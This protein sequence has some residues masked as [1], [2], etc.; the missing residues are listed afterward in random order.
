MTVSALEIITRSPVLD[1]RSFGDAG[2]YE[3]VAGILRFETDPALPINRA[4]TDLELAPRNAAG[5]V[6]SWADFYLLQPVDPARGRRRLLLDVPN[7]GRKVAL[8]MFNSTPRAAPRA[9]SAGAC[10]ASG[11]PMRAWT[12][13]R[14]RTAI[15]S[16]IPSPISTTRRPS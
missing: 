9:P 2:A 15:T 16:H 1:G 4:I 7:R 10:V 13:F 5:R 8:G 3:K 12:P 14:W 6:E 11:G